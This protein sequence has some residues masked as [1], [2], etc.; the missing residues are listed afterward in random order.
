MWFFPKTCKSIPKMWFFPKTYLWFFGEDPVLTDW[1][2]V[3]PRNRHYMAI[4][5][6]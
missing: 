5:S 1:L 4:F 2:Q 3:L 6:K